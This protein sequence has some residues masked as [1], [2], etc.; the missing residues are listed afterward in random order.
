MHTKKWGE[1]KKGDDSVEPTC[2]HIETGGLPRA[3]NG[4]YKNVCFFVISDY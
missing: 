2:G 3:P 1:R 4:G